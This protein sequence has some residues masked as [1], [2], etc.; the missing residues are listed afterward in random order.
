MYQ[1]VPNPMSHA[2]RGKLGGAKG[3][4]VQGLRNA[5]S[6]HMDRIRNLEIIAKFGVYGT[7]ARWHTAREISRPEI[8]ELCAKELN[9]SSKPE[10]AC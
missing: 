2:D 10:T 9:E 4:I 6:G 3:G 5:A 1:P 8:C 7:H